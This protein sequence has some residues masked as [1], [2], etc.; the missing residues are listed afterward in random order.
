M[1]NQVTFTS[2]YDDNEFP[3][4]VTG[5][6]FQGLNNL[7]DNFTHIYRD[8]GASVNSRPGHLLKVSPSPII[9][10]FAA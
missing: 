9:P 5:L 6:I 10:L 2:V 4:S 8:Q 7:K 1:K 3:A